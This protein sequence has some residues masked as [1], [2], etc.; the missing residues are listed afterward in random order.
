ME[1]YLVHPND[2]RG[3]ILGS[4]T[5]NDRGLTLGRLRV[6]TAEPQANNSNDKTSALMK[7]VSKLT[8]MIIM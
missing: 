4:L 2:H 6:N 8:I 1:K 3:I 7:K 5:I